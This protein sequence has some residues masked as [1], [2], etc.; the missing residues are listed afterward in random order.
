MKISKSVSEN[1]IGI[2]EV[3]GDLDADTA[4]EL[5]KAL[6]DLLA[7]GVSRLVLDVTS[8]TFISSVGLRTVLC[9]HLEALDLGGEVRL[10]GLN[11]QVERIFEIAGF[12]EILHVSGTRREALE[13]WRYDKG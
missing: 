9:A 3:E 4:R 12:N 5:G 8:M 11:P 1:G 6:S 10:F 7:Q 13:G 2:L